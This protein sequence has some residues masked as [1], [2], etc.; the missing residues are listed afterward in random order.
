MKDG[1]FKQCKECHKRKMRQYHWKNRDERLRYERRR[2][3]TPKRKA[4]LTASGKRQRKANSQKYKARNAVSNAKRDGKIVQQPCVK[5]GNPKSE[6]HHEDY[7][8]PLD[9]TWL[10]FQC[11]RQVH[12]T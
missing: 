12:Q 4:A 1:Y 8:R 10:C 7:S 5:C 9:V 3:Q 11:H 6:A 2:N